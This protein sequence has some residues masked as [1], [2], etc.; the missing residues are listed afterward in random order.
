M[1]AINAEPLLE[2]VFSN[3]H[4]HHSTE[5]TCDCHSDCCDVPDT[6]S[7]DDDHNK[8]CLGNEEGWCPKCA[9][10]HQVLINA[11]AIENIFISQ[12]WNA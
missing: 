10:Q 9:I 8:G 4:H 6:D 11:N 5:L 3:F 1:L 2:E 12:F 7:S